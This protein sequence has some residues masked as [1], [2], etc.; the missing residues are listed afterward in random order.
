MKKIS[1]I[2]TNDQPSIRDKIL[3]RGFFIPLSFR[4]IRLITVR[5]CISHCPFSGRF[6]ISGT[7]LLI[8]IRD[9]WNEGVIRIRI[10]KKA[11]YTQKN[12]RNSEGRRPL[13]LENIEAD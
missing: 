9:F 7:I 3:P 5:D 10:S 12:L 13:G 1:R 4:G 6:L 2:T 8:E 11:R